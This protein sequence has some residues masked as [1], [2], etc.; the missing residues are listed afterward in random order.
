MSAGGGKLDLKK[1]EH[2]SPAGLEQKVGSGPAG[3]LR[4]ELDAREGDGARQ[5]D[6]VGRNLDL[7]VLGTGGCVWQGPAGSHRFGGGGW[8]V[9]LTG[10]LDTTHSF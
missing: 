8:P 1:K 3:H 7:I 10:S 2:R 4:R 5:G 6:L 9:F